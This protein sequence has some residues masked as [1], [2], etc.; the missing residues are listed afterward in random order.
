S[1]APNTWDTKTTA[2]WLNGASADIFYLGDN[3]TFDDTA[4]TT[5]VSLSGTV[6]P[7]AMLMNNTARSYTFDGPGALLAGTLTNTAGSVTLA[8]SGGVTFGTAVAINGGSLRV[9]TPAPATFAQNLVVNAGSV[10]FDNTA[11]GTLNVPLADDGWG[12]GSVEKRGANT[13]TLA[14]NNSSFN[15]SILV[16]GGTLKVGNANALGSVNGITTVASG[17]SLDINGYSLYNP[18]ESITISGTGVG[19]LGAIINSGGAQNN[20][21]RALVLAGNASIGVWGNRWDVRG[22]SGS[23]TFSGLVNLNNYTLTKLGG[24]QI[25]LVDADITS[26]GSI[27]IAGG[28]MSITRCN[29]DSYG[30]SGSINISSNILVLENYS[31]GY[32]SKPIFSSGGTLRCIGNSFSL[33]SAMTSQSGLTLDSSVILT[34]QGTISGPGSVTKIGTGTNVLAAM[35]NNWTGGT[36]IGAG[37]L[38][39]GTGGYDGSLPDRPIVNN[40]TLFYN[41]VINFTNSAQ[42]SGSGAVRKFQ[43]SVL[44]ITASNSYT[45]SFNTGDGTPTSGG[46][47]RLLNSYGLGNGQTPKTATITRAELQ[48]EGSLNIPTNIAFATSA[49]SDATGPGAGLVAFRNVSGNNVINGPITLNSGGGNSE[50]R[51]DAG[52]LTLNGDIS[53]NTTARVL[54]LSGVA[55]GIINGALTNNGANIPALEKRDAGTWTLNA[56]NNFTGTTTLKGGTL[57][58]GPTASINGTSAIDVQSNATLNVAAVAGGFVLGTNQTLKGNGLI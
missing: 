12:L 30:G 3:V 46:T 13:L 48:L 40:G 24:G 6:Q 14:A 8:N 15:G 11:D 56:S 20:A 33:L 35:D 31:S 26:P 28:L 5:A 7:A 37:T 22:P 34:H 19:G 54:V 50:F 44:T 55:T 2:N 52:Q 18:G 27:E 45:G 49:N 39:V 25:S 21:V 38:Q 1:S 47:I 36:V 51:V 43:D 58:L 23:G 32:V 42:I 9:A 16:S 53:P 10:I 4:A 57:A 29:V 17:A 41:S